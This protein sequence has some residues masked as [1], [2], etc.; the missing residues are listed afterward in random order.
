MYFMK[1]LGDQE[2]ITEYINWAVALFS[3]LM[4]R[5]SVPTDAVCILCV[6]SDAVPL[7]WCSESILVLSV[8]SG[9]ECLIWSW[10]SFNVHAVLCLCV[11]VSIWWWC[12]FSVMVQSVYLML[13]VLSNCR[14]FQ[15]SDAVYVCVSWCRR[16]VGIQNNNY[17][18]NCLFPLYSA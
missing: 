5:L 2:N 17:V 16:M 8:L 11:S 9:A 13:I 14:Q 12:S 15:C 7:Y 6:S 3:C 4:Q 18:S 10:C 1:Q